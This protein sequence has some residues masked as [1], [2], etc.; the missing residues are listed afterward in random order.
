MEYPFIA[1]APWSTLTQMVAPDRVQSIG[2][3]ELFDI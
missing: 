1:I 3:M 2:Q